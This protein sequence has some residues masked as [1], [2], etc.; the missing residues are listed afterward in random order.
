LLGVGGI[1]RR[2]IA[3]NSEDDS[4]ACIQFLP[5]SLIGFEFGAS[6]VGERKHVKDEDDVLF[7]SEIAEFDLL[8]VIAE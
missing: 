6:S 2:A 1:R 4:V 3:T 5:I 7:S 8:P